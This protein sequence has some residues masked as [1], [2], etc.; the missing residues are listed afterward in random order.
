MVTWRCASLP[1]D[2]QDASVRTGLQ[3]QAGWWSQ[4]C[5][6]S[7][8]WSLRIMLAAPASFSP[9]SGISQKYCPKLW[10]CIARGGATNAPI[11]RKPR[12]RQGGETSAAS[13]KAVGSGRRNDGGKASAIR[14]VTLLMMGVSLSW[15]SMSTVRL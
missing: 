2:Y 1:R 11:Y 6:C 5:K 3:A 4:C 8:K 7:D 10:P 13:Q 14:V 12:P 9:T 15:P